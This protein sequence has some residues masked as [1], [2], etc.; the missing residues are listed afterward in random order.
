V[1]IHIS[2]NWHYNVNEGYATHGDAYAAWVNVFLAAGWTAVQSSDG[3]AVTA[4]VVPTASQW[5]NNN[6]WVHLRD[7]GGVAGRDIAF[8]RS[9]SAQNLLFYQGKAGEPMTGGNATTLPS[10]AGRVQLVGTGGTAASSF[11]G[12]ATITNFRFHFGAAAVP[13]GVSGDVYPFWL[14]VQPTNSVSNPQGFLIVDSL[15]STADGVV[16][17]PDSEPWASS[18]SYNTLSALRGWYRAGLSGELQT[19]SLTATEPSGWS[20]RNPLTLFDDLAPLFCGETT[21][22]REQRKG[23]FVNITADSPLRGNLAVLSPTTE[24]ECRLNCGAMTIPWPHNVSF[25]F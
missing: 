5:N 4:S 2:N 3:S 23:I 6:A 9:T 19:T 17:D 12:T 7:P 25:G 24:G 21:G 1:T 20:G 16:G 15:A 18:T 14:L 22:G 13:S 8:Q 10:S 11:F